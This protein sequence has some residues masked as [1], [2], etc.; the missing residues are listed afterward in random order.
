MKPVILLPLIACGLAQPA[1]AQPFEDL[2][3]IDA[4]I[5]DLYGPDAAQPVDRRLKLAPCPDGV[6]IEPPAGDMIAVRCISRGW[7]IRVTVARANVVAEPLVRRGEQV[8]LM[9]TGGGYG[10][11]S[12]ATALDEGAEGKNIRVKTPTSK[13]VLVATVK[14]RGIV[15][16]AP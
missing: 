8:E 2:D 4:E 5:A 3:R 1:A 11:S 14:G 10:V 12:A 15:V 13:T 9:M 6:S 16:I 7:R